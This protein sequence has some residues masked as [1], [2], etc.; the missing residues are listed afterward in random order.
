[1]ENRETLLT[2][3]FAILAISIIVG[4]LIV[5][6]YII[7]EENEAEAKRGYEMSNGII[8]KEMIRTFSSRRFERCSDGKIY[9]NQKS[10]SEVLLK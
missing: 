10:Y 3:L 8:C 6:V 2:V 5:A 7:H 9:L 1:M 4:S